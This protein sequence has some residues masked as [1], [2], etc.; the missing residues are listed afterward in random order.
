MLLLSVIGFMTTV[1]S[2]APAHKQLQHC[3][4]AR[5]VVL[6]VVYYIA[7]MLSYNAATAAQLHARAVS[8]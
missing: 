5:R 6:L 4:D 2:Q 8:F 7:F 1:L 3:S